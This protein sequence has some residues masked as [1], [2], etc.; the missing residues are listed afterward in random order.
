MKPKKYITRPHNLSLCTADYVWGLFCA[1]LHQLRQVCLMV[2]SSISN[3]H[4]GPQQ[5]SAKDTSIS[6]RLETLAVSWKP[7]YMYR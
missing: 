2:Y 4:V 1:Q 3:I 7:R 5:A 6:H